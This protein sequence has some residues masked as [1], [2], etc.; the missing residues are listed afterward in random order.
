MKAGKVAG[1]DG[2]LID[3]YKKFKTKM[4]K[5]LLEMF[6]EAFDSG[7]LPKSKLGALI[8]LLL[9]LFSAHG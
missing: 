6:M 8:T 5:P 7:S 2:L 4:I 9:W 3:L 1:P